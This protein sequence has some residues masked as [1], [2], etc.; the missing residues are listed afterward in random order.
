MSGHS[1]SDGVRHL[2]SCTR[3]S[4]LTD[5]LQIPVFVRES[6]F[7]ARK[8]DDMVIPFMVG[9]EPRVGNKVLWSSIMLKYIIPI[10]PRQYRKVY[11]G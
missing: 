10:G 8:I 1:S 11:T 4:I 3:V 5:V 6:P 7:Y 2:A 9:L